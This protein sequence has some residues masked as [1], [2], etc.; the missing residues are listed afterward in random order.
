MYTIKFAGRNDKAERLIED[1]MELIVR[2][3]EKSV[4]H[5]TNSEFYDVTVFPPTE[6]MES[7]HILVEEIKL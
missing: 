6:N 3:L 4:I 2:D 1:V 7:Y 5:H